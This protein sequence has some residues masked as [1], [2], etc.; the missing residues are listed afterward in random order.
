MTL[1]PVVCFEG[2]LSM[3]AMKVLPLVFAVLLVFP[4]LAHAR[5][6]T[7]S[8]YA[9]QNRCLER[10]SG[11]VNGIIGLCNLDCVERP[12]GSVAPSLG[13]EMRGEMGSAVANTITSVPGA[14]VGIV[15]Q[16]GN[17]IQECIGDPLSS[18]SC[19]KVGVIVGGT[20]CSALVPGCAPVMLGVFGT[21]G[22]V[23]STA[24]CA[25][26]CLSSSDPASCQQACSQSIA[27][28]VTTAV[29]AGKVAS[30]ANRLNAVAPNPQTPTQALSTKLATGGR[31]NPINIQA[32]LD[33]TG[34]KASFMAYKYATDPATGQ[35]AWLPSPLSKKEVGVM[36][37]NNWIPGDPRQWQLEGST[38]V[39]RLKLQ[40]T[41]VIS[42]PNGAVLGTAVGA[43]GRSE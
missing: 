36:I 38:L 21:A 8:D 33:E 29:A 37:R 39:T 31:N 22:V 26:A 42:N 7:V 28:S 1:D 11:V 32:Q 5:E 10:W 41:T 3:S 12:T 20:A 13:S 2:C 4:N 43:V 16:V 14:A 17:E 18:Y 40:P 34:K 15:V 30:Q 24:Y 27:T 25:E 9:E 6:C 35:K 23:S 19:V